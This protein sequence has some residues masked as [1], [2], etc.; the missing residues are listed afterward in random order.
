[1]YYVLK[2]ILNTFLV[3]SVTVSEIFYQ[4]KPLAHK[5]LGMSRH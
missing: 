4:K 2:D 5:D 3:T 1:M